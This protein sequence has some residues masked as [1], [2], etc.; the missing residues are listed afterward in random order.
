[1]WLLAGDAYLQAER[2]GDGLRVFDLLLVE[3]PDADE[4]LLG[5]AECLFGLRGARDADA[6]SI[7][8]RIATA[9]VVS[10][11]HYWLAQ[12]RMLQ[13]LSRGNRNVHR[14]APHIE[15]LRQIDRNFGGER[16]RMEFERLDRQH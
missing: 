5:R 14:I 3:H 4:P 7:Y 15:R 10:S 9:A 1:M 2:F 12:L 13:I 16:Y 6:M 11:D 8:R